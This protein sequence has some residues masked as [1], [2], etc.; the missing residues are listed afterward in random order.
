MCPKV[1]RFV[2]MSTPDVSKNTDG[3]QTNFEGFG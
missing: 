3:M 1:S 2:G